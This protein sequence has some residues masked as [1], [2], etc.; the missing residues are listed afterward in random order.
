MNFMNIR[1]M[2]DLLIILVVKV[3]TAFT[4][5]ALLTIEKQ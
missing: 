2:L 1:L 4:G 5:H 3:K